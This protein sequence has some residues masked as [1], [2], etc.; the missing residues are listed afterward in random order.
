[1]KNTNFVI[2]WQGGKPGGGMSESEFSTCDSEYLK[3]LLEERD[4][5]EK[6]PYENLIYTSKKS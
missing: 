5:K 6:L 1:M 3:K 2:V 4:E